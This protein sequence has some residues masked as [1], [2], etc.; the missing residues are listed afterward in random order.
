MSSSSS[1]ASRGPG[2]NRD[3]AFQVDFWLVLGCFFLSGFAAL[4]YQTAWMRQFAV[5]FGTSELAI[6]TV[7]AAYM[8]GLAI[9]AGIAGRFVRRV[10]RPVLVYGILEVGIAIG[11]VLV[12]F[13]IQAARGLQAMMIGGQPELPHAGG[14]TQPLFYVSVAFV[15]LLVPTACMGATLPL[16]TRYAVK[17]NE[18]V[19][20]RVGAL[21]SINT[22][23]AVAGTLSA[24]FLLLP[25]LG[26]FE[27]TLIAVAA[28]VAVFGIAVWLER[29]STGGS[30][31]DSEDGEV[32]SEESGAAELRSDPSRGWILPAMLVSGM[33]AFTYEVMWSRL[34]G[35]VIGGSVFAFCTMLAAFLTG[36]TLGSAVASRWAKRR[37]RAVWGFAVC[38]LGCALASML[39]YAF[40]D[41]IPGIADR[42]GAGADSGPY[43]FA[44]AALC[45]LVL[46]PSTIFIGGTYPFGVRI[47][48]GSADD[49]GPASGRVYA[50]NTIG[51]VA[52]ALLSGFWIVPAFGFDGTIRACVAVSLTLAAGAALTAVQVRPRWRIGW[53]VGCAAILAAFHPGLPERV[54]ATSPL[55][56]QSFHGKVIFHQVGRSSTVRMTD[57]NGY[58]LIQNNGLPEAIV[59]MKGTP[60]FGGGLHRWL[61]LLPILA[62]PDA[63]SVLVIGFGG[64]IAVDRI[65]S[66][67]RHIDVIELE[68]EVIE[69]NRRIAHVREFDPLSDPRVRVILNDARGALALSDRKYDIIVSQ[70]SHPWTAGASHLYTQEF[71]QLAREHLHEDGVFLQWLSADFLDEDLF[72]SLGATLLSVFE[73]VRMYQPTSTALFLL[74]SNAPLEPESQLVRTGEPLRS[75]FHVY[76][77]LP[78]PS[79]SELVATL[80]LDE[81]G[82]RELCADGKINTDNRNRLAFFTAP[83]KNKDDGESLSRFCRRVDPLINR[84]SSIYADPTLQ[85]QIN[86][87][88]VIRRICTIGH[89]DRAEEYADSVP[90]PGQKLYLKALISRS[91][92]DVNQ[93]RRL[94]RGAIEKDPLSNEARFLLCEQ[95]ANEFLAGRVPEDVRLAYELL[96]DPEKAVFEGIQAMLSDDF[97]TLAR[98]EPRLSQTPSDRLAYVFSLYC[99]AA[100]RSVPGNHPESWL[101]AQDAI[102]LVDQAMAIWRRNQG[103]MMRVNAAVIADEPAVMLET[104]RQYARNLLHD[105]DTEEMLAVARDHLAVLRRIV[106]KLQTDPR[107]NRKL[108]GDV[109]EFLEEAVSKINGIAAGHA[110]PDLPDSVPNASPILPA[111]FETGP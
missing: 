1:N 60:P 92:G 29:R 110:L 2:R 87:G 12:P 13:G 81:E 70:P 71:M 47:L 65:P 21:Y 90:R 61:T 74:S 10:S 102:E 16:L 63:E 108:A 37:D 77:R 66:S 4:V 88:T 91:I 99:R 98:L 28:N 50:W 93:T 25:Y 27:T 20:G 64:G 53:A 19:G 7:L 56:D 24:G 82:L 41:R 26:L 85:R 94:A 38:Q 33:V 35:H 31:V 62:R 46:L 55:I 104:S 76:S 105:A 79:V 109:G 68:P 57:A 42:L 36:I 11:A 44:N 97:E 83:N 72:R 48:A 22:F 17:R 40:I 49:A 89:W 45:G 8:A 32:R 75:H 9:G 69:A 23:G 39:T 95:H 15:L 101:R 84:D 80:T 30:V 14:L 34:L 96:Q 100:W 103:Y 111:S 5:V 67:V 43:L 18:Q 58:Y 3:D 54:L 86:P 107:S 52:G 78:I 73:N 51:S 6:A 106:G 59:G